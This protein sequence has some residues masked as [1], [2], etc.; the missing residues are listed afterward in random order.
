MKERK[1]ETTKNQPLTSFRVGIVRNWDDM[2]LVWNHAFYE[3]L[4]IDPSHS[5]ILLTEP[6]MNP[7]KNR[8]RMIT[9]MFETYHFE[10]VYVAVQA[11]LTLYA[12]G[13]CLN[14]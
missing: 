9:E 3:K 2:K 7:K 12:Q 4:K 13:A 8:E 6:P 11:V 5:K 14:V 1:K 10:G